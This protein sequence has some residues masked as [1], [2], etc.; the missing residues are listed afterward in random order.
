MSVR[1]T[2]R[3]RN[4]EALEQQPLSP[5]GSPQALPGEDTPLLDSELE[6]D[7]LA[8]DSKQGVRDMEAIRSLWTPKILVAAYIFVLLV[9]FGNGLESQASSNLLPYAT[10]EFSEHAL[11]STVGISS[12]FIAGVA[13]LP[14]AKIVDIWGRGEGFVIMAIFA[15]TGVSPS[16]F[17]VM[18]RLLSSKIVGLILMA[19]CE[20]VAVYVIAQV[21]ISVYSCQCLLSFSYLAS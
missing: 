14:A 5:N 1:Q 15:T 6:D 20:N 8:Q 21:S 10:S 7:Q 9:I 18:P 16:R 11:I 4:E 13:R 19:V 17:L 2:A 3:G 12:S